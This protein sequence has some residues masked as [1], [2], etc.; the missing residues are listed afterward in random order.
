M[1]LASD[2]LRL[3]S[4]LEEHGRMKA[5]DIVAALGLGDEKDVRDIIGFIKDNSIELIGSKR[6]G[7]NR[8]YWICEPEEVPIYT[9]GIIH[10][11]K[12]TMARCSRQMQLARERI[13]SRQ[14]RLI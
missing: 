13:M 5:E 9:R 10:A 7:K 14:G 6:T 1:S 3:L 8:G 2:A 12:V 11:A 4:L